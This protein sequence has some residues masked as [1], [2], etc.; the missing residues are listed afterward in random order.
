MILAEEEERDQLSM[1]VYTK[2]HVKFIKELF[3]HY[4]N[5]SQSHSKPVPDTGNEIE[6]PPAMISF[7][8]CI[9]MLRE[10]NSSRLS[11]P[12]INEIIIVLNSFGGKVKNPLSGVT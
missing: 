1:E 10:E 12:I 7:V 4:S 8:D 5:I 11:K 2:K 9:R 3:V 6:R